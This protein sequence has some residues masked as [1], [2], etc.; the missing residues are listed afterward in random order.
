VLA[1][2]VGAGAAVR[3]AT[4]GHQS[5]D[6]GETVT[7]ARILHPT[8]AATFAAYS[9]IERSGPLY[10]TLAWV[11][12]HLFGTGEVALRSLSA[13][14][15]TATI[16]IVYLLGRELFS[17]RAALIAALLAAASP[18]LLW[19][20]QEARSYP[21]FIFFGAA[22]LYFFVRA[23]K[24]PTRA[25]LAGWAA[26]GSLSLCT[27]YFTAFAVGPE[28]L[29]LLWRWR[30]E[31]R[32]PLIATGAIGAVGFALL[33]L[34][35]HQEGTGRANSFTSIPVLE[36]A[37]SSLVKFMTGEGPATSGVWSTLPLAFRV[38][39]ILALAIAAT[40]IL[41]LVRRGTPAERRGAAL[42]GGVGT[43][44]FC[45]PLALALGGVD[46]IE[47]R[48]LLG[49]LVPV[50][51]VT[52]GGIDVAIRQLAAHRGTVG[53]AALPIAAPAC[54]FCALIVATFLTPAF[55]RYDWRRIGQ[56]VATTPNAGVVFAEPGSA[57]KPLHYFLGHPLAPLKAGH[58]PCGVRTRTI[59]TI[60]H[61]H[62]PRTA[63]DPPF[64]LV[65]LRRAPQGWIVG[66][67]RSRAPQPLDAKALHRLRLIGPNAGAGVDDAAPVTPTW[68]AKAAM[69]AAVD[70]GWFST[71]RAA[72]TA[73]RGWPP[74]HCSL[75][76]PAQRR[77]LPPLRAM[78]DTLADRRAA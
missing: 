15:G 37:A 21:L 2:I 49:S 13:I 5:F 51:V 74:P 26:C 34:A 54:V 76:A 31:P 14:F 10:Y 29:W 43:L 40:A 19:Y 36:R 46:Y 78:R 1:V 35:I 32:G 48:N 38:A 11:W 45:L 9:T 60:T 6:S 68:G 24:R 63:M 7:A 16:P 67:F 41:I 59:V 22:T 61:H 3:F 66:T 12:M 17:R 20:S 75:A 72:T 65:S 73:G 42:V 55:Q 56:L 4:L 64:R 62:A 57:V 25:A 27:H 50:L 28:A 44:A 18:D 53:F 58:Y 39:G 71:G 69:L 77:M 33:P 70:R 8:Y 30:R 23:S 52:A 47:P